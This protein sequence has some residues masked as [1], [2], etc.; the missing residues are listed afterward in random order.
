MNLIQEEFNTSQMYKFEMIENTNLVKL[1]RKNVAL[2]EAMIRNDSAYLKAGDKTKGVEK[3]NK[4]E[5][6]YIG[7]TAYCLNQLKPVLFEDKKVSNYDELVKNAVIAIDRD[8]STHLNSDKVGIQ[9]ISQRIAGLT[10]ETLIEY[11]KTPTENY[12]LISLISEKTEP[13][14]L[15]KYNARSNYSFATKFCHYA[16]FYFFD[17]Q[18]EQYQDNFAIFDDVMENA[19]MKY[20]EHYNIRTLDNKKITKTGLKTYKT[21]IYVVDKV[22]EASKTDIS[23]NGFDHLLWYYYKGRD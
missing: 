4:G 5:I 15:E 16:C 10:K 14:D 20:V 21:F 18:N 12:E 19:I 8:N 3:N 22:I 17:D 6:T 23:R 1:N 11:L 9:Q 7:S 13:E 2:V